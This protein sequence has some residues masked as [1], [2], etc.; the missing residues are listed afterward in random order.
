MEQFGSEWLITEFDCSA[1]W[2]NWEMHPHGDEFVYLLSGA[3]MMRLAL[4][5]GEKQLLLQASRAIIVPRGVWHT[6]CVSV[7]SKMLF[8]TKG[9]DTQ[10]RPVKK[11]YEV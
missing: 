3:V 2:S 9:R 6:A 5:E 1:D 7:P 11:G 4:P 10:H 8:V